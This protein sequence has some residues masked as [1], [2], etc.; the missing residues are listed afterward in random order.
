MAVIIAIYKDDDLKSLVT[1]Y[2]KKYI[3]SLSELKFIG[4]VRWALYFMNKKEPY[5]HLQK[6]TSSKTVYPEYEI[7]YKTKI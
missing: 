6:G 3:P 4:G 7:W 1:K 2:I 5:S